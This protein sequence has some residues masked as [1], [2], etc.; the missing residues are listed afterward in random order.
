MSFE[1]SWLLFVAL[2]PL[3][4]LAYEWPRTSRR[5]SLIL[6]ALSF[7]A[8]IV[9]LAR[10]SITLPESKLAVA[11]LVDTSASASQADLDR[12]SELAR[13]L[14]DARGRNWVGIIP[15]ARTTRPLESSE[16]ISSHQARSNAMKLRKRPRSS[17][18][19]CWMKLA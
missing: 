17:F 14:S 6:K 7:A 3:G 10:P 13:R 19:A 15:F 5:L 11:V 16:P 12:A 1:Y 9:A 4:W 8:I 2:L 18:Q